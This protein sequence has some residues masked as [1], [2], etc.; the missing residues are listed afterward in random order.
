MPVF[1]Q[2]IYNKLYL[3]AAS[4]SAAHSAAPTVFVNENAIEAKG[5]ISNTNEVIPS[6]VKAS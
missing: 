4:K 1:S 5:I 6:L 2:S 3:R